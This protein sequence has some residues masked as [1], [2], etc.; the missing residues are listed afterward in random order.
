[1]SST[2][3]VSILGI[4]HHGPGS[5]RS[6]LRALEELRPEIILVEGPPDAQELIP[7]LANPGL[8]PPA[9]LLLYVPDQPSQAVYYPFAEFSP[10]WQA[11]QYGLANGIPARFMD[12]PQAYQLGLKKADQA[13]A[14]DAQP[15]LGQP[16]ISDPLA[17]FA[18]TA[19]YSD[20]ERWW[21]QM[22]EQRRAEGLAI[23]SGIFEM[24]AAL[25]AEVEKSAPGQVVQL[26][27]LEAQRE[28]FMRQSIRAA[29]AEGYQKVAVVCGAW[30]AP[31]LA[32]RRAAVEDEK[33][34]KSLE[35]VKV[36]AAWVPWSYGRLS[37][38]SG[39]GAG[40]ESPG[41][42]EALWQASAAGISG[43]DL[44]I[45]W[46]A[47]VAQLLR[48]EDL[49]TSSAHIIEAVRLAEALAAL[50]ERP[51]PGLP[52]LNEAVRTV[53]CFGDD[54]PLRLIHEKLIVGERLGKVPEDAPMTPLQS[55]LAR[56]QKRL[57]LPPEATQRELDLDLRTPN[58]LERSYLLHRLELLQ[59]PWG[60]LQR[61]S[62][63]SG[64]F[65][66]VWRLQWKPELAVKVVEASLWGNSVAEAAAAYILQAVLGEEIDLP[67]LTG[68]VNRA[69]LADLPAA[70]TA[71]MQRLEEE[72]A[73]STDIQQ[74]M[75]ALPALAQ[76]LRYGNVRQTDSAMIAQVVAGLV[77]RVCIGL[78]PAC[79]SLNDDAAIAMFA[80][81][82]RVHQA[83]LLIQNEE[84]SAFWKD[85]L[86]TLAD[87]AGLHG[88]VAGRASALLLDMGV[89]TAEEASRRFGLA[90]SL[91]NEPTQ[92]AAWVEGLL[93]ERGTL[94]V[95]EDILWQVVDGWI[96]ALAG[97]A[98]LQVLPLLRRTFSTF[99]QPERR[100]IGERARQAA[101]A[102]PSSVPANA[103]LDLSRAA[104]VLP[105]LAQILGVPYPKDGQA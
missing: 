60:E 43:S 52:E 37:W 53:I 89:F 39:Y 24:I 72:A 38:E 87:Q 36:A 45:R 44:T 8:Q 91:A 57:R 35:K 34:L 61:V 27:P 64:T 82:N 17:W 28:A 97:E 103:E 86:V 66:E 13:A 62:G 85:T 56:Q 22:V 46:L 33:L 88:L 47:Q 74:L 71:L 70:V 65:H 59:I 78:P 73:V 94:L 68:L 77:A 99:S 12:L 18:Q 101:G 20:S 15:E 76:T 48:E 49:S 93:K 19:G 2:E 16:R 29:L 11:L 100:S 1:M 32:A 10:E 3:P 14:G 42:Y 4:R 67:K 25:R 79:A 6:L 81:I 80:R 105:L 69:L 90:L 9:A 30:H 51:V 41:W 21:E 50:R 104:A 23:F 102:R 96:S 54:L 92:A 31:A 55:D 7:W 26:D 40:I 5:A 63:K 75:D 83:L 98:F 84:H 58:D 95:H